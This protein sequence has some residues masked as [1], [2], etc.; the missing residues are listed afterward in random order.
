MN[1]KFGFG[2][3]EWMFTKGYIRGIDVNLYVRLQPLCSGT[4]DFFL[5]DLIDCECRENSLV[6]IK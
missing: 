5:T 6:I 1:S 3:L 4:Y 2:I